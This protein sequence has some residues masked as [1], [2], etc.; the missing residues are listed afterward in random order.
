MQ[1]ACRYPNPGWEPGDTEPWVVD[2]VAAMLL[3][4]G[5]RAVLEL[6]GFHGATSSALL[7]VLIRGQSPF[8]KLIVVEYDAALAQTTREALSGF[9]PKTWDVWEMDSLDALR[10][11]DDRS[12]GF[13]WVDDSHDTPHV[14]DELKLLIPKMVD[15]G[16]ILFHDVCGG[17]RLHHVVSLYGGYSLNLPRVSSSGGLGILQVRPSTRNITPEPFIWNGDPVGP[18]EALVYEGPE[19]PV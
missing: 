7:D 19:V 2:I 1:V 4:S 17:Y 8:A 9:D 6:G 15:D 3:A 12:I 13:A 5:Q 11:L 18:G 14:L 16:L 10:Q